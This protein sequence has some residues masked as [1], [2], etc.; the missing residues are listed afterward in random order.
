MASFS[1]KEEDLALLKP[2][3]GS[4]EEF[5]CLLCGCLSK[6]I[7]NYRKHLKSQKHQSIVAGTRGVAS[8]SAEPGLTVAKQVVKVEEEMIKV[9]MEEEPSSSGLY[10]CLSCEYVGKTSQNY[11]RHLKTRKHRKSVMEERYQL[12]EEER[13]TLARET[14][15]QEARATI[16]TSSGRKVIP[17]RFIGDEEEFGGKQSLAEKRR[18]VEKYTGSP[19]LSSVKGIVKR[20][21]DERVDGQEVEVSLREV[22]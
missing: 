6:N 11:A 9:E 16:V 15:K 18:K 17:K 22:V 4:R 12:G 2:Y 7:Q 21:Q 13:V 8:I 10:Q 20:N 3:Q 1:R 14:K 19:A 5:N